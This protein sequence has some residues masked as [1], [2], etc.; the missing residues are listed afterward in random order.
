MA[1]E[2]LQEYQQLRPIHTKIHC[3]ARSV[4]W[5]PALSGLLKVNFDRA[6]FAE[7]N[8]DGLGIIIRNDNELV[9]A[10]LTQQIALP[11]STEMVELLAACRAL[12]LATDLGFRRLIV[13]GDSEVIINSIDCGN[14]TQS[15][16]GHILQD[17]TILCSFFS[18]VFFCHIKRLGNC[19]AHRLARLAVTSPLDV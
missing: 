10:A 2:G 17:I 11:A 12:S 4:R 14:R 9:M 5:H 16:Y 6:L 15:E 18:H 3:T 8:K 1:C 7:Q 19:L 13:E